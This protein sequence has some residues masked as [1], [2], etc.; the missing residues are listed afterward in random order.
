VIAICSSKPEG[1]HLHLKRILTAACALLLSVIAQPTTT[2]AQ[3]EE[4]VFNRGNGA[5]PD[6]L[7]PQKWGLSVESVIDRDLFLG[8]VTTDANGKLIPGAA[9]SWTVSPDG[10]VYTFTLREHVWSDAVPV[11]AEDAALGIRRAVDPN[12]AAGQ[13]NFAY[14]IKNAPEIAARKLPLSDL[15]VRVIDPRTLE[16]ILSEPSPELPRILS[17]P[18]LYPTPAHVFA[19]HGDAWVKQGTMVSNGP[20]VLSEWIPN[21]HIKL[22]KNERYYDAANVALDAVMFFPIDDEAAALKRFR[23]GELDMVTRFPPS[24]IGWLRAT[25]PDTVH[26]TPAFIISFVTL[27]LGSPKFQDPRVRRALAM[28]IDREMITERVLGLGEVPAYRLVPPLIA[29]YSGPEFDFKGADLASRQNEARQLLTDAGYGPDNPLTFEYRVRTG[30]ANKRVAVAIADMWKAVGVSANMLVAEAKTH[31]AFLRRRD[32]E[33]ADGGWSSQGDPEYFT[34]LLLTD[35]LEMNFG[36]YSNAEFD[37]T[38]RL[39]ENTMNLSERFR[40]F[41]EAE[42]I[43]I[44][45]VGII[46]THF[47]VTRNLVSTAVKGWQDNPEDIHPSQYIRIERIVR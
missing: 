37:R 17:L 6:T 15:G 10:R 12:T 29:G 42:A 38:T 46:P 28:S 21:S 32:F 41:A 7:D 43:G 44:K 45:E 2:L 36:G 27:N 30:I 35:S 26:T 1:W 25:V 8:L 13:V 24:E 39:A 19:K 18:L 5:E 40:L 3:G 4:M 47:N 31:Y 23:A 16:I 33:A 34:Y 14:K 11:T 22:V 9:E 20:F